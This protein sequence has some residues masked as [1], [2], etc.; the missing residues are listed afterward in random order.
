MSYPF[1]HCI[2]CGAYVQKSVAYESG[3]LPQA[4]LSDRFCKLS[5]G[6]DGG[7]IAMYCRGQG[8]RYHSERMPVFVEHV[9]GLHYN[10]AGVFEG[11]CCFC[12]LH[13]G[14]STDSFRD[15]GCC[16]CNRKERIRR[17][18]R[19]VFVKR[20]SPATWSTHG[21]AA[22]HSGVMDYILGFVVGPSCRLVEGEV[23]VE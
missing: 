19:G 23:Q 12:A 14:F 17:I 20:D 11:C 4:V 6:F 16:Y 13:R 5:A 7:D 21:W 1:F 8:R 3:R 10:F 2:H 9:D 18:F 15:V 22:M